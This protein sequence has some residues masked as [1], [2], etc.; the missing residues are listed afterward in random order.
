MTY[1]PLDPISGRGLFLPERRILRV[2]LCIEL[3]PAAVREQVALEAKHL[4]RGVVLE[5]AE[6]QEGLEGPEL[7]AT[8]VQVELAVAAERVDR[9][10]GP[11]TQR[12]QK[13]KATPQDCQG[14]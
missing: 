1:F 4:D 10:E 7:A 5:D 14:L 6:E 9:R 12:T 11:Q 2:D 3:L 13:T 8:R